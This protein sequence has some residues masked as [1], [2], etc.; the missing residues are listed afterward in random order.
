MNPFRHQAMTLAQYERGTRVALRDAIAIR[1]H[2]ET[3]LRGLREQEQRARA[4]TCD[5]SAVA[6][7]DLLLSIQIGLHSTIVE[8]GTIE[9]DEV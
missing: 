5:A 3:R 2:I 4:L 1:D 9:S 6:P 8:S 7:G